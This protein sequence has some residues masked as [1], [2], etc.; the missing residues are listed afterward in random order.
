MPIVVGAGRSGTTLLRVMLDSHSEFAVPP[1][2]GFL[3]ELAALAD[4]DAS[5]GLD[6]FLRVLL[7]DLH[8]PEL[9]LGEDELRAELDKLEPFAIDEAVRCVYRLFAVAHGKPR[10]GDKTPVYVHHMPA[11]A[12][13]LPE[14]HFIHIIRDGRDV[15][16]SMRP[17]WFSPGDAMEARAGQWRDWVSAGLRDGPLV[18]HYIEV[19]YE[20][21]VTRPE[22]TLRDICAFVGVGFEPGMLDYSS[23]AAVRLSDARDFRGPDGE[24]IVTAED[25]RSA[26][27]LLLEPPRSSRAG[28]WRRELSLDELDEF[29]RVAGAL[30]R[31]LGY[32]PPPAR[33]RAARVVQKIRRNSAHNY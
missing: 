3:I 1:E 8:W 25:R 6:D 21:L 23:R 12:R 5:A 7:A 18:P 10:Y 19:R 16:L 33:S 26:H 30:R 29:E 4:G 2:T 9:A 17:M 20:D 24:L 28:R 14:A 13:L 31:Q 11:I 32:P 27:R 15:A 22:A